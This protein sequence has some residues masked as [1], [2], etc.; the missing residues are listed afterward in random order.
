MIYPIEKQ[1]KEQTKTVETAA[2]TARY[3]VECLSL[4]RLPVPNVRAEAAILASSMRAMA[5]VITLT[6]I[7]HC[8][9]WESAS[10]IVH[11]AVGRVPFREWCFARGR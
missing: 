2:V 8:D 4:T 7:G 9:L 5:L 6:V 11:N 10:A 3:G 1:Q